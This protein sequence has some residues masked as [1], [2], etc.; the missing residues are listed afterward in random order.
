MK[1]SNLIKVIA[2]LVAIVLL[3]SG[4]LLGLNFFSLRNYIL[5]NTSATTLINN[6]SSESI[7]ENPG[8]TLSEQSILQTIELVA[9]NAIVKKTKDEL[10][11]AAI[12]GIIKSLN[13]AHADY[14][15]RDEYSKILDSF[16]GTMSGIGVVVTQN[17]K[18]QVVIVKVIENSPAFTSGIKDNDIIIKVDGKNIT[19][20]A[21]D[22]IVAAIKGQEGTEVGLTVMRTSD[23]ST[24][25]FKIKRARFYVPNYFTKIINGNIMYIQYMDFQEDGAKKLDVEI[26]K[27]IDNGAK[28]IILDLRNNLGGVLDDAVDLCNL[29]LDKGIITTVK[30]RS[31]NQDS[32][33]EFDAKGG[34]YKNVPLIVL[35]N[36]YSASASE[37]TAGALKD[38]KRAVLIGEKSYGKGTVQVLEKLADGSGIKF[39]TAKYYLP[40][41]VT[42]DGTGVQPDIVVILTSQDT[43]DLQLNKAVEEMKKLIK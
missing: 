8:G 7:S 22:Q 39:T 1:K 36:G 17:D 32:F 29:F 10:I 31:N 40:S 34:K 3:G 41:G 6:E 35:I 33:Q 11:R 15:T 19:G 20:M 13:D 21:L 18:N 23:N 5:N 9:A 4:F 2:I 27:Q 37:L 14:F 24:L 43:E 42:I 12:E 30:G 16:S 38:N 28:G 25:D 26:Q